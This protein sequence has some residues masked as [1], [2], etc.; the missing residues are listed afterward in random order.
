[1]ATQNIVEKILSD[2]QMEAD[3]ILSN[4]EKKGQDL[5]SKA[6]VIALEKKLATEHTAE[7]YAKSTMEKRL[8][9]A[10]LESSK[11]LLRE[12]RKAVE[13]IYELALQRL[14]A[15]EKE[16]CLA[17]Y[18]ALLEKYA[19]EGDEVVLSDKFLYVAEL[20]ALPIVSKRNLKISE[21]KL[22]I[23]GGMKLLG[24]LADKDLSF[25]ALLSADKDNNQAELARKLF[26]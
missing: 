26:Q 8:A 3:G 1:M 19:E 25:A 4:A 12:K 20:S 16:D 13:A 6:Q 23:N 11:I 17:L 21:T 10:R 2:A 5:V 18:T 15:L 24:K 22:N 7:E 14:L 9:D